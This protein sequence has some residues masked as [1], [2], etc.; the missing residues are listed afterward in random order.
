MRRSLPVLLLAA[1]ALVMAGPAPDILGETSVKITPNSLLVTIPQAHQA[2]VA[3][4]ISKRLQELAVA[5][6]RTMRIEL[7]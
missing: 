1:S 6:D 7:R 2:L 5:L 3:E 4:A